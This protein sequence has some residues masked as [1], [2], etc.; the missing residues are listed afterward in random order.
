MACMA[1]AFGACTMME[2]DRS[3][4]PTGLYVRFVYDYN[5]QRADM[6]KDHVGYVTVYVYDESGN[7]VAEKS[8]SNTLA[9]MPLAQYGYTMH[10]TPEELSSAS[11]SYADV[12]STTH[13]Y[14][15]QAVAMQK[16]W[17]A[18]LATPGAKYRRNNPTNQNSLT[19]TLDYDAALVPGTAPV[20]TPVPDA[21]TAPVPTPVLN[22]APVPNAAPIPAT[23]PNAAPVP[24]SV[25]D[26]APIPATVPDGSPSGLHAVSNAAPLDTLWHTLKVMTTAP[27][28]GITVPTIAKTTKPYSVYPV[29]DQ[30]VTVQDGYAT[31]ATISL[32]RDTKHL[33]ITL[34][35]LDDPATINADD[36]EVIILDN[37][38]TLAA[39]NSLATSDSLKY[40][41][42]AQWT[43][44]YDEDGIHIEG[45][46]HPAPI[47][48]GAPQR[49]V[50]A[51]R[52]EALTTER[53][54]HYN[55][56]FNRLVYDE[57]ALKNARLRIRNIKSGEQVAD[58]N[59]ASWL[60]EGRIA[61]DFYNYSPQEYLDREYDYALNFFLKGDKWQ[62]CD[63]Q[64]HILA[65][66]LRKQ[67]VVLN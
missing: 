34:R 49:E 43:T 25:P 24:A 28:D 39:D 38:A 5:T 7:K 55:L 31:Y 17:D 15:L 18:A 50:A 62:Y 20:P 35:Q 60:A 6:F 22:A 52:A 54:A 47:P 2:D 33:N 11:G 51:R 4:C 67:N 16:D 19:I 21:G 36:Y 61:Y 48:E 1:V 23:I 66:A 56:M 40:A 32:I 42:Y 44:R 53:T 41:P 59:L 64:I 63:I 29:E 3:D 12:S 26:A 30:L 46:I 14:R 8:V 45:D 27:M 65:W 10:F 57:D 9:T 58:I 37:N 13:R